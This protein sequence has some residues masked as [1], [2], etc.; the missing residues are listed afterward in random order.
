ML[1]KHSPFPVLL[2]TLAS[3]NGTP[4]ESKVDRPSPS[5]VYKKVMPSVVRIWIGDS[6]L[7]GTLIAPDGLVATCA[8]IPANIGQSVAVVTSDGVRY[9]AKVISKLAKPG[10]R[11]MGKD[12]ALVQVL[13][14]KKKFP[15]ASI[16]QSPTTS[17]TFPLLAIG[18]PDTLLY[19][20]DRSKDPTYVRFGHPRSSPYQTHPM[21]LYTSI[22]GSGGDSGGPLFDMNGS[23]IG[24]CS[25]ADQSGSN[26]RYTRIEAMLDAWPSLTS[27]RP[28]RKPS[29]Q[30]PPQADF[31]DYRLQV[32]SQ[33]QSGV[34]E[35][36][37]QERWIGFGC[38]V[39]DGLILTK[40][41]EL[42]P[43]LRIT[44]NNSNVA[45]A[46][47]VATDPS[48]DLALVKLSYAPEL[49]K[50]C[51][52]VR[53]QGS[54]NLPVASLL[55]IAPT[56]TFSPLTGIT[57]F[58]PRAVPPIAGIIPCGTKSVADGVEITELWDS[59]FQFR[60]RKPTFPLRVG[61]VITAVEGQP[62]PNRE[63]YVKLVFE[64]KRIGQRPRVAGEPVQVTFTRTGKSMTRTVTLE[65]SESPSMQLVRPSS[66]R[67]SGFASAI[68]TD[69]DIRPEH[70][71][72]PVIDAHGRVVGMVIGRAPFIE[73]LVLPANEVNSALRRMLSSLRKTDP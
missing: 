39:D 72:A 33:L 42:G 2:L 47:V 57:S 16:G 41:S 18:F 14:S 48:T 45:L 67:Y 21:E 70:A 46:E 60:L 1:F 12:V 26:M 30:K 71:G 7:T 34:V 23:L 28:H 11:R 25:G 53:W 68:A 9:P 6:M 4:A 69:L 36:R 38:V 61:D 35:V 52:K 63:A 37:S 10:E 56:A 22:F 44:M 62:T 40:A 20:P 55:A 43:D 49:T 24:I 27:T 51:T 64:G 58:S 29:A 73:A 66:L 31:T 32:P 59:Y 3:A 17:Q 65:F 15:F 19:G 8:H 54:V 5:S 50:F 13:A